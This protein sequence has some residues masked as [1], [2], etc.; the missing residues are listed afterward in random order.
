MTNLIYRFTVLASLV[1]LLLASLSALPDAKPLPVELQ[2]GV[3]WF[4]HQM[5]FFA[6]IFDVSAFFQVVYY[7]LIA[8]AT[9]LSLLLLRFVVRWVLASLI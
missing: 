1:A 4:F 3:L 6:P 7:S 5:Y 8:S 2:T 9:Y